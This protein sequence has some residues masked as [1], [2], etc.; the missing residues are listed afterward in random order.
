MVDADPIAS[1]RRLA[2]QEFGSARLVIVGGSVLTPRRTATSDLDVVVV[3]APRD[4][5]TRRSLTWEGWPVEVLEHDER[6]LAAYCA[7]NLER[8]WP[9]IPRL[10]AEGAIVTDSD[11]LGTRLQAEMRERLAA[12]PAPATTAELDAHRY[13]LTDLL[14]DLTGSTDPAETTF[15]AARALTKTAQLALLAA[16]RWQGTGKWLLRELRD[17]DPDLAERLATSLTNPTRLAAVT[18]EVL[19]S[20]GGPLREGYEVTDPR[21]P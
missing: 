7:D 18:R 10:I 4:Q 19:D 16:R 14:D 3:T 6:S 11:G 5:P 2:Q 20:V 9:G 17:H 8:R 1:A 15:T 12:G 21:T 13:D